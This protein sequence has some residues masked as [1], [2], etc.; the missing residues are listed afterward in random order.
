MR[1]IVI[2]TFPPVV[3]SL[4]FWHLR[5]PEHKRVAFN[6]RDTSVTGRAL[7]RAIIGLTH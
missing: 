2:E 7:I 3:H 6:W 1:P 5:F 4:L